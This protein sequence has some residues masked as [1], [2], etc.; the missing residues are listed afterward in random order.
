MKNLENNMNTY[1]SVLGKLSECRAHQLKN[2]VLIK[3]NQYF[4]RAVAILE[5]LREQKVQEVHN[6]FAVLK[7][8]NLNDLDLFKQLE[9]S[10]STALENIKQDF[11]NMSF[12]MIYLN[13]PSYDGINSHIQSVTKE[14][15]E[16]LKLYTERC[17]DLFEVEDSMD[18]IKNHLQQMVEVGC[19]AYGS[20]AKPREEIDD[21]M[22]QVCESV[23]LDL[24]ITDLINKN[25]LMMSQSEKKVVFNVVQ[26]TKY[27]TKALTLNHSGLT[28]HG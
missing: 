25:S 6:V 19:R 16:T 22:K 14:L 4:D 13:K 1:Q 2:D 10:G 24:A 18:V 23:E 5:E 27:G 28:E 9:E 12:S 3:V 11:Q 17:R 21:Q 15:K 26:A 8:D 20:L 7:L